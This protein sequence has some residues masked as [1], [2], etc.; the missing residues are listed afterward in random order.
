MKRVRGLYPTEEEEQTAV[1]KYCQLRRWRCFHIPNE[2]KRT[3][4]TGARLKQ[5]GMSSG[6]PDLCIPIPMGCY[7]GMY[8]EM[9]RRKECYPKVSEEQK[10]WIAYLNRSGYYAVVA[11]GFDEAKA[12][13]DMYMGQKEKGRS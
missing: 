11:Y 9:K 3:M 1:V 2:G 12:F 6:V 5:Q 10:E 4:I 13:I 7:H 8:L